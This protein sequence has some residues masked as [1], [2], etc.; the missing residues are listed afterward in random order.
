MD[1]DAIVVTGLMIGFCTL[2]TALAF[3]AAGWWRSAKRVRRLERQ[4]RSIAASSVED[5]SVVHLAERLE[6]VEAELGIL[7]ER[8]DLLRNVLRGGQLGATERPA[9]RRAPHA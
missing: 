6:S 4:L 7:G 3:T 2:G 5:G 9:H 8:Q 1:L